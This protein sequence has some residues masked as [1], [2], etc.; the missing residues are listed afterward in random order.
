M[1]I[2]VKLAASMPVFERDAAQQRVAGK[3]Q[4]G[5]GGQNDDAV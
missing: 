1:R 4:H 5:E 2:D 3:G